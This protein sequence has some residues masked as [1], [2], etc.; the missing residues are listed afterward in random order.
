MLKL[1][2][3]ETLGGQTTGA[4]RISLI[5]Y[6]SQILPQ[7]GCGR[8]N[9]LRIIGWLCAFFLQ[10]SYLLVAKK[11]ICGK[12]KLEGSNFENLPTGLFQDK[13]EETSSFYFVFCRGKLTGLWVVSSDRENWHASDGVLVF[14]IVCVYFSTYR[15]WYWSVPGPVVYF[16]SSSAIY[17]HMVGWPLI[18]WYYQTETGKTKTH[19]MISSSFVSSVSVFRLKFVNQQSIYVAGCWTCLD[20][21]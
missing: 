11:Q 8:E 2:K 5:D 7:V 3:S 4:T 15:R 12:N 9:N 10:F 13:K 21:G 18:Y 6:F 17:T 20:L 19:L 14:F 1:M 16:E